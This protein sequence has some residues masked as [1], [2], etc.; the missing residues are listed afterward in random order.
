MRAIHLL[1]AVAMCACTEANIALSN[2]APNTL[3]LNSCLPNGC[4]VYPGDDDAR[5]DQSRLARH[6]A[7]LAPFPYGTESWLTLT[8]CV[9]KMYAPFDINVTDRDPGDEPHFEIMIAGEGA[10]LGVSGAGGVAP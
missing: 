3:Y 9:Q 10:A 5:T 1:V 6:D 8:R 4:T 7:F 2:R